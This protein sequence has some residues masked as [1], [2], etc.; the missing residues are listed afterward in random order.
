[1]LNNLSAAAALAL[2]FT[3]SLAPAAPTDGWEIRSLEKLAI[4]AKALDL[5]IMVPHTGPH[6]TLRKPLTR[7]KTLICGV[8]R[9]RINPAIDVYFTSVVELSQVIR[10]KVDTEEL[11]KVYQDCRNID[12]HM[13]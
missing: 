2:F 5:H 4:S 6:I 13:P 7:T 12:M 8:L 10:F 1:M 9:P 11:G 3:S